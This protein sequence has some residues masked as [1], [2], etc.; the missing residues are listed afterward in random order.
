[1][2]E[3]TATHVNMTGLRPETF[4]NLQLN[5]GVFL[6]DFDWPS[7]KTATA[8]ATAAMAAI[9]A[10]TGLLGATQ[11]GGSFQCTP[12]TRNIEVDGLRYPIVG[13]TVIDSWNVQMTGTLK[14]VTPENYQR[15][16][17]TGDIEE[18]EDGKVKI[19][20]VRTSIDKAKD[21]LPKLCWIGDTSK[22][23]CLIELDNVMNTSGVNITFADRG[24]GT[25]PFTFVAHVKDLASQNKAPCRVVFFED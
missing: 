22:G 25:L 16:L 17:A 21:Y 10:G 2:S 5:A 3:V 18:K 13:S 8:L 20:T 19:I 15:M 4:D 9:K 23:Y 6:L 1:M 14:E 11:G 12:T 24:E 7:A